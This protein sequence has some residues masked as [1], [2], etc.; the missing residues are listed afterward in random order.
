MVLPHSYASHPSTGSEDQHN[1]M[2]A[3]KVSCSLL[4]SGMML[5]LV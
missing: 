4:S 2:E 3:L 5:M 1:E